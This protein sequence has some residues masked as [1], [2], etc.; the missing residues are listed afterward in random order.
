MDCKQGVY[1]YRTEEKLGGK[2]LWRIPKSEFWQTKSLAN[3]ATCY[4]ADVVTLKVGKKTL[5]NFYRFFTAKFFFR[6]VVATLIGVIIMGVL[7]TLI[8]GRLSVQC[9]IRIIPH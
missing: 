6:T 4:G 5:A 9:H 1:S 3:Y 7:I 2:K 8:S